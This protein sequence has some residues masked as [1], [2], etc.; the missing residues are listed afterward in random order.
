MEKLR[1]IFEPM[2]QSF[3]I[4]LLAPTDEPCHADPDEPLENDLCDSRQS[5]L[6]AC[7]A[8]HLQ[9][10]TLRRAK[11][12]TTMLCYSLH[13]PQPIAEADAA[14]EQRS[15]RHKSIELHMRLLLHTSMCVSGTCQSLNC[16]KMKV[17][18]PLLTGNL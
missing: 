15:A 4:A 16:R 3:L 8:N 18:S 2:K 13:N 6:N 11:H 10:D 7:Q 5:F 1:E 17:T 9:F 12:S 14:V